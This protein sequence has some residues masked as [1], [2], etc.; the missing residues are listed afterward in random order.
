M[1]QWLV[2]AILGP[3]KESNPRYELIQDILWLTPDW[4]AYGLLVAA[5]LF[6]VLAIWSRRLR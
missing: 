5:M 4:F 6:L 2:E 1:T 3:A